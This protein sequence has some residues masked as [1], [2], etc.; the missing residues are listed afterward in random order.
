VDLSPELLTACDIAREGGA[1]VLRYLEARHTQGLPVQWKPGD[2][3][4]TEADHAVNRLLVQR[5]HAA[6]PDDG[7]LTEELPDNG[8]RHAARY[9]WLVDPIDGT[10]DFIAG[11]PGFSVMI[12]R[13]LGGQPV[14]GVVYVPSTGELYLAEAGAGAFRVCPG[15]A[16]ERLHVSSV[17]D[18]QQARMV[19]SASHRDQVV[20]QVREAAGIQSEMRIGSVGTKLS[21]IAAGERDLYIN[22][23]PRTKLWDTCAPTVILHE[24]GGRLTDLLGEPLVYDG[25]ELGHRRGLLASNGLLHEQALKRLRPFALA[26]AQA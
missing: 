11:R 18:L 14:L 16:P 6:F 17:A 10:K 19:S 4:V 9:T 20:D 24:A 22:P 3:P 25:A 2:E 1:L 7:L 26:L 21:L 13:L 23:L 8:S 15:G 5:L 12:G